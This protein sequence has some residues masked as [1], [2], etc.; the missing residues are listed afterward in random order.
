MRVEMRRDHYKANYQTKPLDDKLQY[1]D[2]YEDPSEIHASINIVIEI[3][4]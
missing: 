1:R 3:D 4:R 2:Q